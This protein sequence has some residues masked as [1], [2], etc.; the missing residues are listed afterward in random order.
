M[1]VHTPVSETLFFS[2]DYKKKL[3][4]NSRYT[5]DIAILNTMNNH[6]LFVYGSLKRGC[7]KHI[8][9]SANMKNI[10][11]GN[12]VTS[13]SDFDMVISDPGGFPV[14][15]EGTGAKDRLAK[16]KGELWL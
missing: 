3:F 15:L 2:N 8:T 6:Y 9:L 11:C 12:G 13:D 5:D 14:L 1:A 4:D 7:S 16:V 10:F